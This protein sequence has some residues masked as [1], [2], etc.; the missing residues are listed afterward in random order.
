MINLRNRISKK[1]LLIL[2]GDI[3]IFYGALYGSLMIR[4]GA[5]LNQNILNNHFTAF[6][7]IFAIW[8]IV[9]GA[10]GFYDMRFMK[11]EKVF[12]YR[13]LRVMA[14][15][16][17]SA[18]TLFYLFP[19]EI[20][21][22]RNLFLIAGLAAIG[23]FCWRYV[24]NHLVIRTAVTRVVFMGFNKEMT[25]LAGFLMYHPQLGHKPVA[26]VSGQEQPLL[27]PEGLIHIPLNHENLSSA[28]RGIKPEM[29]IISPE[30]KGNKATVTL[31]LSLIPSGISIAEFPAFHEAMTGKIPLSLIEEVWFLENLIGIKKRSYEFLKRFCD[32]TLS[33]PVGIAA[34]GLMPFV[35]LVIKLESPGPVFFRQTR[36]G[37]HGNPFT[38][39][40]F[41]S[42]VA[43][44]DKL[45][46]FKT[47]GERQDPRQTKVGSFMR[48]TYLD[49]LPQ[50]MNILRGEMSFIGPRPERPEYVKDLK[51][52]IP[53]YATRFLVPPGITGWAQVN[54][55]NDA[56]VEDAPE[57]LQY[58][59]YYIKNRTLILDLLITL[60]TLS[61][62]I[63]RQG[64]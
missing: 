18:I 37:K 47:H 5:G 39:V 25:E 16:T 40:K 21:P 35:A 45:S 11:N 55:E 60:R 19:F 53:F 48:K 38:L 52:R 43:N 4:Y 34:L 8:I 12:L 54:M 32:I 57:K 33:V 15:N 3:V 13:L 22:R 30:M 31:L 7:I 63:R 64:R 59:L 36:V 58:D 51:E 10:F 6:G 9:F 41:R 56:S 50:I 20:E 46:G 44:A 29:I 23:I 62:I 49:E 27:L 42:M 26:F 2:L 24:F 1:V 17:V 14:I 28:I 61:A